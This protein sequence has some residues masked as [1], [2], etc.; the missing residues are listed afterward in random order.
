DID[1]RLDGHVLIGARILPGDLLDADH[2]AG[3][4]L[5]IHAGLGRAVVLERA[6][7]RAHRVHVP[8]A[9]VGIEPAEPLRHEGR[10][11]ELVVAL[12][13]RSVRTGVDG[14]EALVLE[15]VQLGVEGQGPGRLGVVARLVER[16]PGDADAQIFEALAGR[17]GEH[18]R[19]ARGRG[20]RE[21]APGVLR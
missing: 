8:G 1:A 10:R 2:G 7:V 3:A 5:R 18:A 12:P 21:L 14:I 19:R 6:A 11:D 9:E 13:D 16:R 17:T 4:L 15:H 20:P